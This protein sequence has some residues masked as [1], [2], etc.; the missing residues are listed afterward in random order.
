MLSEVWK[1]P[2]LISI[3]R[4]ISIIPIVILYAH[5]SAVAY[6]TVLGLIVISYLSDYADGFVARKWQQESRLGLIL[7]PLADKLWTTV[8]IILLYKFRD[9][10]GWMALAII[11]RDFVIFCLNFW[12]FRRIK[13]VMKSDAIGRIYMVVL[14]LVVIALT[15]EISAAVWA[16]YGLIGLGVLTVIRYL[17]RYNKLYKALE[18]RV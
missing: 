13:I 9:M 8:M 11:G 5:T 6:W 16:G 1:I 14:G 7:D 4:I 12:T 2:N 10:P 18:N 3:G 15:I 17:M